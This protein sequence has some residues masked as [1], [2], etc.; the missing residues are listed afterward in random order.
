MKVRQSLK[1]VFKLKVLDAPAFVF[2]VFYFITK[3][4]GLLPISI[5]FNPLNARSS[6][7]N[8]LYSVCY[9][10]ILLVC[11]LCSQANVI[12]FIG[13]LQ[14]PKETIIVVF[15]AQVT[16]S[17]IRVATIYIAQLFN[18][19]HLANFINR[20]IKINDMFMKAKPKKHFIDLKLSKWCLSKLISMILQVVLI[21]VPSV[22][23]ITIITSSENFL[24]LLLYFLIIL[25]S[26]MVLILSTGIYFCGMTVIGQFYRNLNSRILMLEKKF[27][28]S[29]SRSNSFYMDMQRFCNLS[30][31]LDKL[32]CL[33]SDITNHAKLFNKNQRCFLMF[34]LIEY[35][36]ILLA[37]VCMK[38][39]WKVNCYSIFI[40][41]KSN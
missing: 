31:E 22:G 27:I 11:L 13:I 2:R 23:F 33:Y 21:L 25:Y 41:V 26:H 14:N 37:E 28:L 19:K 3:A 5:S 32:A 1:M 35:F 30:D 36:I 38:Q 15:L 12:A 39:F 17:G 9:T 24:F 8:V 4:N 40:H 34:S 18:H 20:S 29:K 6:F 10:L 16:C 7:L